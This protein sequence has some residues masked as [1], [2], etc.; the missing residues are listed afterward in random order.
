MPDTTRTGQGPEEPRRVFASLNPD[1][2]ASPLRRAIAAAGRQTTP[3]PT[4]P[5]PDDEQ[6]DQEP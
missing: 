5:D 3:P 2:T 1:L 4:T 6:E